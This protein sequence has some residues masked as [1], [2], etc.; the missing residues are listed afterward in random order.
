MS[1]TSVASKGV[2]CLRLGLATL[3]VFQFAIAAPFANAA[4]QPKPVKP[5]DAMRP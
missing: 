1:L 3:A 5:A 4:S 2:H